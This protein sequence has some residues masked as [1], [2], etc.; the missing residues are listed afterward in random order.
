[1]VVTTVFVGEVGSFVKE[2]FL[3]AGKELPPLTVSTAAKSGQS[4]ASMGLPLNDPLN[5]IRTSGY[6]Y[7]YIL[8]YIEY[9]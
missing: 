2:Y 7:I 3:Q 5:T 4:R 9:F 1:M 6:V 8:N